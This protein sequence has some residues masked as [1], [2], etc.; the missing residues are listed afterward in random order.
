MSLLLFLAAAAASPTHAE[1]IRCV[2]ALAIVAS[3]QERGQAEALAWPALGGDGARFAQLTGERVMA[4]TGRTKEAVRDDI[5][6]A[7]ATLQREAQADG[8][9]APLPGELVGGCIEMM[10]AA[11]PPPTLPVCAGLVAIAYDAAHARDGLSPEA[12][13]LATVASVLGFRAREQLRA[14]G[15]SESE[16]DRAMTL[17]RE[18]LAAGTTPEPDISACAELARP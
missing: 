3:E 11:V 10:R 17:A 1:Q 13:D 2:A 4:E 18:G 16:I 9:A 14:E 5:L 7:V 15:R 6:A 12:K 8:G